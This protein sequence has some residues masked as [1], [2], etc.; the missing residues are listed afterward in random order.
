M[1]CPNSPSMRSTARVNFEPRTPS[2]LMSRLVIH[3]PEAVRQR[4]NNADRP[5]TDLQKRL[6][7]CSSSPKPTHPNLNMFLSGESKRI[8]MERSIGDDMSK[9]NTPSL[10]SLFSSRSPSPF[11]QTSS[12]LSDY[13]F[14]GSSSDEMYSSDT[15]QDVLDTK[16]DSPVPESTFVIWEDDWSSTHNM[17]VHRTIEDARFESPP[18]DDLENTPPSKQP[19]VEQ[20]RTDNYERQSRDRAKT[21]RL[22]RTFDS[23]VHPANEDDLSQSPSRSPLGELSLEDFYEMDDLYGLELTHKNKL[24]KSVRF[25]PETPKSQLKHVAYPMTPQ[26]TPQ[27]GRSR[28]SQNVQ[29]TPTRKTKFMRSLSPPRT[30]HHHSTNHSSS[31]SN[32]SSSLDNSPVLDSHEGNPFLAVMG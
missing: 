25:E 15:E 22:V 8:R 17:I 21:R 12:E 19:T 32:E 1:Q 30:P 24:S 11:M 31:S 14:N 16:H 13:L 20:T 29:W 10:D 28:L 4:F 9:A 7:H 2:T 23:A 3:S 26:T 6:M 18:C 5:S 27:R